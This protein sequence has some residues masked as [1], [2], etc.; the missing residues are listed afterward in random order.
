MK[1]SLRYVL[2]GL[3]AVNALGLSAQNYLMST[4]GTVNACSGKFYDSGGSA[5]NYGNS[6]NLTM[7]FCGQPGQY[8]RISFTNFALANDGDILRIYDGPDATA[9]LQGSYTGGGS[10]GSVFS[11]TQGGCLTFVFSSTATFPFSGWV[12]D[13]ACVPDLP[14]PVTGNVCNNARPFC[15]GTPESFPNNTNVPSMGTMNCL[16]TTPNPVWYYLKISQAGPIS[17]GIAQ[18]DA[19]GTGRDVDYALWGPYS[20]ITA[21]CIN[22]TDGTPPA[23]QSCS[24][25]ASATETATITN[26]VVGQYYILLLT[27][28]SNQSGTITFS[29]SGGTGRTDCTILCDISSITTNTSGCNSS[30]DTYSLSGSIIYTGAPTTGTLDITNSCGGSMSFPATGSSPRTYSFTN[31]PADGSTCTITATFSANTNCTKTQTYTAPPMCSNNPCGVTAANN[32]PVCA[33]SGAAFNLTATQTQGTAVSYAWSGPNSYTSSA[34]N[35]TNVGAPVTAGSYTYTVTSTITGSVTCSASTTVI[36][37]APPT[38]IGI[39]KTAAT[40]STLGSITINSVTQSVPAPPYTFSIDGGVYGNSTSTFPITISGQTGGTHSISVKDANGCTYFFTYTI[41]SSASISAFVGATTHVSCNGGADGS[42]TVTGSGGVAPYTYEIDGS[43]TFQTSG[44]F[45]GLTAGIHNVI[46]K[47]DVGCSG[48]AVVVIAEPA[49]LTSSIS[50]QTPTTCNGGTDGSVTVAGAGGTAPYTYALDGSSTFQ[51]S[52][53]FTGLTAAAHSVTVKDNKG[54]TTDQAVTITQPSPI[55]VTANKTDAN[56]GQTDGTITVSNASGGASPYTYS[57]NG[58]VYQAGTSFTVAAGTYTVYAK[59]A[60]N[61]VGSTTVTVDNI[62]ALSASVT[63]QTDILCN[64]ANSGSVT[65]QGAGTSGYTYS[66]DGGAYQPSGTFNNLS[67]GAHIVSVRDVSGCMVS[68]SATIAEPTSLASNIVSQTDESCSGTA[69][70]SVTIDGTG[71]TGTLVCTL[72]GYSYNVP[73]TF[74]GL[75][76]G[77]YT[78]T[79]ADGN[80]CSKTQA[81]TIAVPNPIIITTP[82]VTPIT[83]NGANNGAINT[84]ATGGTGTLTYTW[85]LSPTNSGTL[86]GLSAG[87][88]FVTIADANS[89]FITAT[90]TVTE[91]TAITIP[92]PSTTD[93]NCYGG[94]SGAISSTAIGGTGTLNYQWNPTQSNSGTIN[95]LSA[96]NYILTVTDANSCSATATYTITQPSQLALANL[97]VTAVSC[98]GED[99]GSITSIASGGVPNYTY[100]WSHDNMLNSTTANYLSAGTYVQTVTDANGCTASTTLIVTEPAPLILLLST[101]DPC[102]GANAILSTASGGNSPYQFDLMLNGQTVQSNN[103]GIFTSPASG[104]YVV[105]LTDNKGCSASDSISVLV[106]Q[107]DSFST[108]ADTTSCYGS[109]YKDGEIIITPLGPNRPYQ[110]SIDSGRVFTF[111]T[112]FS[113]L[114]AG[115]YTI[116]AKNANGCD[117]SFTVVVPQP[118]P[119]V[120]TINPND[121]TIQIGEQITLNSSIYP[122]PQSSITGYYWSPADG[123]SCTD[124][125]NPTVTSYERENEYHLTI[126]Y[127]TICEASA[128]ATI[129]VTGEGTL[130]IP[131]AFSPNGDGVNDVFEIYGKQI[132]TSKLKV[133]NRWGEKVYD[134]MNNPFAQWDGRYQGISQPPMIYT[135][136]AEIEFLNGKL[137]RQMGSLTLIR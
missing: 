43:G 115:V 69:D 54:C 107:P 117:T 60:N 47:D 38:G 113:N 37:N 30:D 87:T 79:L 74:N 52:G 103:N 78:A 119:A 48:S 118:L 110:Y 104:D 81:F 102:S 77:T 132:K 94:N 9:P 137:K 19:G 62:S 23:P 35:P 128:T 70:G 24:Y 136:E 6:Q 28:F 71:G 29:Q 5:G 7:T 55:N 63:S 95:N 18:Q 88:Y 31:L 80:G 91:P 26:A 57:I 66:L 72:N 33:T 58:T 53:T 123:L 3:F 25:S 49:V 82:L 76:A 42:A 75:T 130:Y 126:T 56:C 50:S 127:N 129:R 131:N 44:T 121:T 98:G 83:C 134:S 34:Q 59:D 10:P 65:V 14:P 122:Y 73:A 61:C 12:A 36:V 4:G 11:S 109:Q 51:T 92:N 99:D 22:I 16:S 124:C 93:L 13:I 106:R 90:Y 108:L 105:I 97:S 27:N 46:V 15:T 21:A 101:N 89:C 85:N 120:A 68:V 32:G 8:L 1:S 45:T 40:C 125:P 133:F 96:G 114:G 2:A 100:S 112:I 17:I 111:D 20:D 67:G 39:T 84:V 86:S 135:Y 64:G 116:I 41:T